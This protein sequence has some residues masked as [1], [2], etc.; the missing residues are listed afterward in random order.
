MLVALDINAIKEYSLF[1]DVGD[2]KTI[3]LLGQL[4]SITRAFLDDLYIDISKDA[5]GV[6]ITKDRTNMKLVDIV[7]FGLKGWKNFKDSKGV[8]VEFR[9]EEKIYP[10]VGKKIVASDESL[11]KL[12]REWKWE[13]AGEIIIVNSLTEDDKKK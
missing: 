11:N 3:F 1:E 10:I 4:D 9:T 8:D 2:E 12:Q 5:N 7:R 6:D 13:L